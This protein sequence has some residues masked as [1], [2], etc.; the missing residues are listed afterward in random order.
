M[1]PLEKPTSDH[2]AELRGA[3]AQTRLVFEGCGDA[4]DALEYLEQVLKAG[5]RGEIPAHACEPA[6]S[7]AICNLAIKVDTTGLERAT[8]LANQFNEML[9][10]WAPALAKLNDSIATT[11]S[12]A[13]EKAAA[14][15]ASKAAQLVIQAEKAAAGAAARAALDPVAVLSREVFSLSDQLQQPADLVAQ[16]LVLAELRGLGA[17]HAPTGPKRGVT[18]YHFYFDSVRVDHSESIRSTRDAKAAAICAA[19]AVQAG[20]MAFDNANPQP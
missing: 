7:Q 8:A 11:M 16:L 9:Q 1:N 15:M 13:A 5:Q 2:A 18:E 4:Q 3:I 12:A 20:I 19:N 10:G 6:A 17:E 14:A